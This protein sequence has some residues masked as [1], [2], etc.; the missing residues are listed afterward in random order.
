MDISWHTVLG[1]DVIS[2]CSRHAYLLDSA[3]LLCADVVHLP[4]L[5]L[6]PRSNIRHTWSAATQHTTGIHMMSTRQS[7][8]MPYTSYQL[9]LVKQGGN[10]RKHIADHS[11]VPTAA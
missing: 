9:E 4:S 6:R 7:A 11:A 5:T 10:I 2:L 3:L 8:A 1:L